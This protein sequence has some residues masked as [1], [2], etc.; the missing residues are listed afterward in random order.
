MCSCVGRGGTEVPALREIGLGGGGEGR[1]CVGAGL[2]AVD[3]ASRQ[4][5]YEECKWLTASAKPP[6]GG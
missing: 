5:M 1:P 6:R 4:G 3:L 2:A